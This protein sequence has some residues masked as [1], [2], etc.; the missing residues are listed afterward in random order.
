MQ[1][2]ATNPQAISRD[3]LDPQLVAKEREILKHQTE[4]GKKPAAVI[5][6]I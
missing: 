6:K 3:Q 2:A 1:I 5:E 4:N